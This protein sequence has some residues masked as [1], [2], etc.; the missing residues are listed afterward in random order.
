MWTWFHLVVTVQ[1][2]STTFNKPTEAKLI[3]SGIG[4]LSFRE[5][6]FVNVV[7]FLFVL[8][9]ESLQMNRSRLWYLWRTEDW[10]HKIQKSKRFLLYLHVLWTKEPREARWRGSIA[11]VQYAV[12]IKNLLRSLTHSPSAEVTVL[13]EKIWKD[14]DWSTHQPKNAENVEKRANTKSFKR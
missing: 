7:L 3:Y 4:N 9:S 10:W 12:L 6:T 13:V 2:S 14:I 8:E 5:H 1:L 11:F